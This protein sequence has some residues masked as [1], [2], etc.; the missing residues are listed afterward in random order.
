VGSAIAAYSLSI[1]GQAHT[2]QAGNQDGG[3]EN[4]GNGLG[5]S[6]EA[7]Q[8]LLRRDIPIAKRGQRYHAVIDKLF[9]VT[10]PAILVQATERARKQPLRNGTSMSIWKMR[11]RGW[12]QVIA[13]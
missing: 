13:A 11:F 1:L 12:A 10:P 7:G 2:D 5:V 6:Q 8:G 3:I 4:A 9:Q